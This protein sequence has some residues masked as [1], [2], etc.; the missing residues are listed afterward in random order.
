MTEIREH[1]NVSDVCQN[2]DMP[3]KT[4]KRSWHH[5]RYTVKYKCHFKAILESLVLGY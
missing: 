2:T 3:I 5:M 4:D 1:S